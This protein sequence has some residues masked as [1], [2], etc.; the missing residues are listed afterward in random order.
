MTTVRLSIKSIAWVLG[1]SMIVSSLMGVFVTYLA[2][3]EEFNEVLED[4]LKQ[5][6]ELLNAMIVATQA[7]P[8]ELQAFLEEHIRKDDEDTIWVTV[9]HPESGW[10]VSNFDHQ[11]PLEERGSD[12]LEGEFKGYGWHGYQYDE[13]GLVVQMFRRDDL[14]N[15]IIGDIAEEITAPT[16]LGSAIS[17]LLLVLLV[18]LIAKP[19]TALSK[20]LQQ[21]RGD[22]LSPLASTSHNREIQT[23]TDN[24]NRLMAE[25]DQVLT[26]ERQFAN[27]VAHEL[28]T[29]LTTIK[30]EL[31]CPDP[32]IQ[33]ITSETERV[34]RIVEQ[35]LTLA[36]LDQHHWLQRFDKV[37][38]EA[39]LNSIAD[40]FQR[41]FDAQNI[42]LSIQTEAVN[43]KGD[44]TLLQVLIENLLN[45][46]LRHSETADRV[47][48]ELTP[49]QLV[50]ED[51]G[52]GV[53][54]ELLNNLHRST[55]RLDSKGEGLG[56][57]V[58]ICQRIAAIH[59]A[60]LRFEA[61]QPGLRVILSFS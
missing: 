41:R 26:R 16:L 15:D 6:A 18:R 53:S 59:G 11:R 33:A 51:N 36:R 44:G 48:I 61:A 23:L 19:L 2:A 9:Y 27:D 29:P 13:D 57:G 3:D 30:L 35:L 34:N 7:T 52:V 24:L 17:L 25:V 22:D 50:I 56:L 4:D 32:D 45:N 1:I 40:K 46:I 38:L 60:T 5:N 47:N 8:Q 55:N 31:S 42:Q 37:L 20:E 14:T 49:Q 10:Q 39:R 43:V 58:T 21:R 28:R 54:P 12:S